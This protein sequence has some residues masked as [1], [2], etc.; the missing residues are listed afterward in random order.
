M[1]TP[2]GETLLLL[3]LLAIAGPAL[4]APCA[5][6]A[7]PAMEMA[8]DSDHCSAESS[9][10]HCEPDTDCDQTC[11]CCPGH[12]ASALPAGD[13]QVATPARGAPVTAYTEIN[14]SPEPE[15]AIRPPIR[16]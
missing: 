4:A 5:G 13:T 3:L 11:N 16:R 10:H 7:Q 12:C 2:V 15:A 8:A 6:Q 9:G 1:R 14:S